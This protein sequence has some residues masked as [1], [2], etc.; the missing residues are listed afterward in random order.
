MCWAGHQSKGGKKCCL[1]QYLNDGIKH[2]GEQAPQHGGWQIKA[3][4]V[5]TLCLMRP[6]ISGVPAPKPAKGN[7]TSAVLCHRCGLTPWCLWRE[8]SVGEGTDIV[9]GRREIICYFFSIS[10]CI[11]VRSLILTCHILS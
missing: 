4:R 6:P 9:W 1:K 11:L 3:T 2:L 7:L 5:R 10:Y 8:V